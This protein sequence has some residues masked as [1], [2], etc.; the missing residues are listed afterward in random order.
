[1]PTHIAHPKIGIFDWID[2]DPTQAADRYDQRLQM[3]ELAD[4]LG[5]H[6]YHLA[7]HHGTPL[8]LAPSPNL[9]L[10][11]AA[12]RTSR[13][14]LGPLVA[15]V[16]LY[17]PLRLVEEISM[18]DQLSRGRLDLGIG[19]G[20]S[21]FELGMFGIDVQDSRAM[22]AE[23]LQI[24]LLGLEK[25]EIEFDGVHYRIHGARSSVTPFQRPYP[26]LWYPTFE[27][28]PWAA[29]HGLN[30]LDLFASSFHGSGS[31]RPGM[32]ARY[33]QEH[34]LQRDAPDRLNAHVADPLRGF[35]RHI[36]I[37]DTLDEA[38][39]IAQPAFDRYAERFNRLWLER[40]G[41]A[42]LHMS[43]AEFT[44]RG[45]LLA[46]TAATVREQLMTQF[47]REGGNYVVGVFAFGDLAT[48][49]VLRSVDRFAREVAPRLGP[50]PAAPGGLSM[51]PTG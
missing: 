47:G 48:P 13:L 31:D 29:R 42:P 46:G 3:V 36:V 34:A 7:E 20:V 6:A 43:Y 35:I 33:E 37:A 27:S 21:P 5:Y 16:P 4:R 19:R 12:A 24:V 2:G 9:F 17:H 8:G 1:M 44:G 38:E 28:I 45:F 39:A 50:L 22:L 32:V 18:L 10:A 15:I 26:P 40:A 51:S 25:G 30:Y 14:R 49:Q 11:A 41:Q 23:A